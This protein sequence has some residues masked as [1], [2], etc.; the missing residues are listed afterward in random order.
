MPVLK[1]ETNTKILTAKSQLL[2]EASALIAEMLGKPEN[3]VMVSLNDQQSLIFAGTDEPAAYVELKS[4][5]LSE[6]H[7]VDYSSKI[8][9]FLTQSLGIPA[10]RIYIEFASPERHLFGWDNTT[11]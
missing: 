4:L 2:Q 3:Y 9:G 6:I 11:F 7:T 8:C 1:I 10:N 5:G